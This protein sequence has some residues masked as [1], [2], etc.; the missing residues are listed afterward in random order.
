[1]Q[2]R[3]F[4]MTAK[5]LQK[6]EGM[7]IFQLELLKVNLPVKSGKVSAWEF[8]KTHSIEGVFC[9]RCANVCSLVGLRTS[10]H[11]VQSTATSTF[12]RRWLLVL[13]TRTYSSRSYVIMFGKVTRNIFRN[14]KLIWPTRTVRRFSPNKAQK[15]G[16][17]ETIRF[18]A[19]SAIDILFCRLFFLDEKVIRALW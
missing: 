3:K 4:D 2:A 7:S 13:T 19:N 14:C 1:M 10:A 18:P 16:W 5:T 8:E 17:L 11:K 6:L 12:A 15:N 9:T